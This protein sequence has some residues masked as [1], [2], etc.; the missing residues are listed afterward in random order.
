VNI[1][2]GYFLMIMQRFWFIQN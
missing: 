2:T 1:T